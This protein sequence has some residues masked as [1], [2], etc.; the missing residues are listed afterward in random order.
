MFCCFNSVY[1]ITPATFDRWMRILSAVD[2]SVLWL[3]A[4]G[5]IS[6]QRLKA[7]AVARGVAADRLVFAS[8]LPLDQHF[9]RH[10]AADLF[11]DT[12]P[13]NAPSTAIDALGAGLPILTLAGS[14]F[15][16]RAAASMLTAVGLPELITHAPGEYEVL[17]IEL[18]R[19]LPQ[20]N[21]LRARLERNRAT[22]PLFDTAQF[23]RAIEQAYE[24]VHGLATAGLPPRDID[25]ATA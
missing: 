14:A 4:E 1:K 6:M 17:A 20:L 8:H 9:A 13:Y 16:G 3:R 25:L 21:G 15:A 18:A 24:T 19:D 11:L 7:E 10:R 5:D 12:L 2:N 22:S 23:A